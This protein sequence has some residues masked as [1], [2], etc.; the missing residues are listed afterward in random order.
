GEKL[1]WAVQK[2]TELGAGRISFLLT[3]RTVV[4]PGDG[5]WD[6]RLARYRRIAQEAVEQCGRVLLPEIGAPEPLQQ[7]V[8]AGEGPRLIL[9]PSSGASLLEALGSCHEG[10]ILL[11]GPE[12]GFTP[13]EILAARAAGAHGV[14]LGRRTLRAETAAIAAA[15]VIAAAVEMDIA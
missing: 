3:Q 9:D 15:A 8:E 7:C 13:E 10:L 5:R 6:S 4:S 11:I 12:G 2:L 1:D 14:S